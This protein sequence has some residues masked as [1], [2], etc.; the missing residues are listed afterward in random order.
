MGAFKIR[1]IDDEGIRDRAYRLHYNEGQNRTDK[2]ARV[3]EHLIDL[4]YGSLP[5]GG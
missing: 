4:L 3:S 2:F 1:G 5:P